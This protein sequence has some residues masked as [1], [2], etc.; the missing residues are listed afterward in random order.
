MRTKTGLLY[1]TIVEHN[2]EKYKITIRL[3][4]QCHNKEQSFSITYTS[5]KRERCGSNHD[6]INK[7]TN[8]KFEIFTK[9]HLANNLGIPL[10]ATSNGFYNIKRLEK[11][12]FMRYFNINENSYNWLAKCDNKEE[13]RKMIWYAGVADKWEKLADKAIRLLEKLTNKK[14]IPFKDNKDKLYSDLKP[15]TNQE[16][17]A[18]KKLIKEGYFSTKNVEKRRREATKI[19]IKN[20][21]EELKQQMKK[22]VEEVKTRYK[23]R[24]L[25]AKKLPRFDNYIYY[26]HRN[27]IA[28]NWC[29]SL[30]GN[31][32]KQDFDKFISSLTKTD[33]KRLPEGIKFKL[34]TKWQFA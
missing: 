10:Y 21:V 30:S 12:K 23:I 7:I 15:M 3:D 31:L 33:Y 26:D 24:I 14:F 29:R 17:E 20:K 9:L 2:D 28:F 34:V 5:V 32:T 22:E 16:M 25:M 8:N 19:H 6:F 4:D 27:T 13:F 18:F 1:E 11:T